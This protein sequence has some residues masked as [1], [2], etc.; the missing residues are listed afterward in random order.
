MSSSNKSLP[1]TSKA[2][3]LLRTKY[4]CRSSLMP[5]TGI[6]DVIGRSE[7]TWLFSRPWPE[8]T[9]GTRTATP[10]THHVHCSRHYQCRPPIQSCIYHCLISFRRRM[11][12]FATRILWR[13]Q[14]SNVRYPLVRSN[15]LWI[16][17]LDCGGT[18]NDH[19]ID[20]KKRKDKKV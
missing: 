3:S 6:Y 13:R 16:C 20:T 15:R 19:N 12:N 18:E 14:P 8:K 9:C 10:R 5:S 1:S 11:T 17:L 4:G 7:Y 2:P